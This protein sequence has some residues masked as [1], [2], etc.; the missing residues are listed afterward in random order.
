[1]EKNVEISG[2]KFTISLK[3]YNDNQFI[4][5]YPCIVF[6]LND[7][8]CERWSGEMESILPQLCD[9]T[10][11]LIKENL[12]NKFCFYTKDD[13]IYKIYKSKEDLTNTQYIV[14]EK[15]L[16]YGPLKIKASFYD[17]V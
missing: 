11:L 10:I 7:K 17:K 4:G 16:V 5:D 15:D 12:P 3:A 8:T 2:F 14:V 9:E 1:M 13:N 6:Y